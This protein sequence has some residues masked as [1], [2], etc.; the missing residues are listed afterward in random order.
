MMVE[1]KTRV[2]PSTS[3]GTSRRGLAAAK[4]SSRPLMK[5]GS[6]HSTATPFSASAILTF[7][8]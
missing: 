5:S 7:C 4:A 1:S 3:A 6:R 2:S 8:A